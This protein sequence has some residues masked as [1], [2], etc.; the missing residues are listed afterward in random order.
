MQEGPDNQNTVM[1]LD[2]P[3]SLDIRKRAAHREYMTF[4]WG[5]SHLAHDTFLDALSAG[6]ADT[7]QGTHDSILKT[8]KR[9]E[10]VHQM[11]W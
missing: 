11:N 6:I 3:G 9:C 5:Q 1:Y 10:H 8:L 4:K 2:L 7:G